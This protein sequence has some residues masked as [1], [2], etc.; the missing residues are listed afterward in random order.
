MPTVYT[1]YSHTGNNAAR[2][3]KLFVLSHRIELIPTPTQVVAF[4]KAC[5]VARY[6]WNWALEQ[7]EQHYRE[8]GEMA[9]LISLKRRWNREKPSWVYESPRDA[10]CQ[11]FA[12]LAKAWKT[13]FREKKKGNR[14][15]GRPRFKKRGKCRDAFYVANYLFSINGSSVRLPVIGWMDMTEGLRFNGKILR[16][17][18]IREANRWFL[19]IA[20][21]GDLSRERVGNEVTGVDL[22]VKTLATL[23]TGESV[24]GPKP[25]KAAIKRLQRAQRWHSR[26]MKGSKNRAKSAMK[27]AQMHRR[28]KNI[29]QDALHKLTTTLCRENQTV[30]IEDLNVSGMLKNHSLA[31]SI[32]DMGFYE[33]RRQL[34]YKAE[35]FG[36]RLIVADRWYPSSKT[37]SCCGNVKREL[38]LSERTYHCGVCGLE[39]D[40]D[41]NAALNL[42]TLG[43]RG[44]HA[45]GQTGAGATSVA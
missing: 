4:Q 17:T 39:I 43:Y 23:S 9:D 33:F 20:V 16:G 35:L 10:N 2:K 31:R 13:F 14:K 29:R 1:Q 27:L 19:S 7:C 15:A 36:T 30:V 24:H 42:R 5:G 28:I 37:C 32:S 3:E 12:E 38:A 22:G 34:A 11:P 25:L 44:T 6:T 8:T 40:R 18:V 45:C 21:E 26:K 41:L